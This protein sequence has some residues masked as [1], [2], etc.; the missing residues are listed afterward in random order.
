MKQCLYITVCIC[1]VCML[2]FIFFL[3]TIKEFW[4][5]LYYRLKQRLKDMP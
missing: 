1:W 4:R 5:S 2:K 3:N